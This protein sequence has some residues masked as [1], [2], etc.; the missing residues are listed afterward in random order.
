M[1]NRQESLVIKLISVGL[2]HDLSRLEQI[3]YTKEGDTMKY[4]EAEYVHLHRKMFAALL[5]LGFVVKDYSLRRLCVQAAGVC[6]PEGII[7]KEILENLPRFDAP[8]TLE[9]ER[10]KTVLV[11]LREQLE[12]FQSP[13]KADVNL[14]A[15]WLKSSALCYENLD[16][17]NRRKLLSENLQPLEYPGVEKYL[18][19]S[20][21]ESGEEQE[22]EKEP[23]PLD[24]P[25]VIEE[26]KT[27]ELDISQR[28]KRIKNPFRAPNDPAIIP[29]TP[30]EIKAVI[31][32]ALRESKDFEM[33]RDNEMFMRVAMP[34][35][36]LKSYRI[37]FF[38]MNKEQM[39]NNK[40]N[41]VF[42]FGMTEETDL[43]V[44]QMYQEGIVRVHDL[45]CQ[46][47]N[48]FDI[49]NVMLYAIMEKKNFY[50]MQEFVALNKNQSV[51]VTKNP[52]QA[53]FFYLTARPLPQH[54]LLHR[55]VNIAY[56]ST[57]M[58]DYCV[59]HYT[60]DATPC[61][62]SYKKKG[63]E[64]EEEEDEEGEEEVKV[65]KP[66]PLRKPTEMAPKPARKSI[67]PTSKPPPPPKTLT[68]PVIRTHKAKRPPAVEINTV[69]PFD[70]SYELLS[71]FL[72]MQNELSNIIGAKVT[73][74]MRPMSIAQS[75]HKV[76]F[77]YDTT[78]ELPVNVC[79]LRNNKLT[80][81]TTKV[82]TLPARIHGNLVVTFETIDAIVY[83]ENNE[84][85]IK[86]ERLPK[87][88]GAITFDHMSHA[89]KLMNIEC[90]VGNVKSNFKFSMRGGS[91]SWEKKTKEE[92]KQR[93]TDHNSTSQSGDGIINDEMKMEIKEEIKDEIKEEIK[94]EFKEYSYHEMKVKTEPNHRSFHAPQS[95]IV[96]NQS[97]IRQ[98][99][100]QIVSPM[101]SMPGYQGHYSTP[102]SHSSPVIVK[103]NSAF[104]QQ[105]P[106]Q[107]QESG[108][109]QVMMQMQQPNFAV[110]H[111]Q[112]QPPEQINNCQAQV[113]NHED[114]QQLLPVNQPQSSV[115]QQPANH[116]HPQY[117]H[118]QFHSP[119]QPNHYS[120]FQQTPEPPQ[121]YQQTNIS[122]PQYQTQPNL[123]TSTPNLSPEASVIV[124]AILVSPK[125]D[126][127]ATQT[128]K[129]DKCR[130][131]S[132]EDIPPPKMSFS[133]P[134]KPEAIKNGFKPQVK[135]NV[136]QELNGIDFEAELPA[137]QVVLKVKVEEAPVQEQ[138]PPT[139]PPPLHY[140][141]KKEVIEPSPKKLVLNPLN[142]VNKI[143]KED[144]MASMD[145][146]LSNTPPADVID[147][148]EDYCEQ[149]RIKKF[150]QNE[151]DPLAINFV[152]IGDMPSSGI[153]MGK[154][155]LDREYSRVLKKV[156]M[157][158]LGPGPKRQK[159]E[160][161]DDRL[162]KIRDAQVY[163]IDVMEEFK[164]H[165]VFQTHMQVKTRS[166]RLKLPS[167]VSIFMKRE[168]FYFNS[169]F[170]SSKVPATTAATFSS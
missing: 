34:H 58:L 2:S 73:I 124:S 119:T 89:I 153:D 11:H 60:F 112:Q 90:T 8:V 134:L 47:L 81:I 22:E 110:H 169:R 84:P 163:V 160:F 129:A 70:S 13:I 3:K 111:F 167:N 18:K 48:I 26:L 133:G 51:K 100:V 16:F 25:K 104:V 168:F 149:P 40:A 125:V 113:Y 107:H 12:T 157:K 164:E 109:D 49:E 31:I 123:I 35:E 78:S 17:L 135:N 93:E 4:T 106:Q 143:K 156:G 15:T 20:R 147:L 162:K 61:R 91:R 152:D 139:S 130:I 7:C 19:R 146:I 41:L 32:K 68:P 165:P 115:N 1:P 21:K 53:A 38:G 74:D 101:V 9:D 5:T 10:M 71:V 83:D 97:P 150:H 28:L 127:V 50:M 102:L 118:Q 67:E 85:K 136:N 86:T 69:E 39:K 77:T 14:A 36:K 30:S 52:V 76:T 43:T 161:D 98:A 131:L 24:A 79:S 159:L 138:T 54:A 75:Q 170:N 29:P 141:V 128:T 95:V 94:E 137:P 108:H 46:G 126:T 145:R 82:L 33:L 158:K 122:P 66:K 121:Q 63:E 140:P 23:Q 96:R 132:V 144:M 155:N 142:V 65:V 120:Q 59:D 64:G 62:Y 103:N 87:I 44:T 148:T 55:T 42:D 57:S 88:S 72:L 154:C 151:M 166:V 80:H 105:Q 99:P 45:C 117:H 27:F 37:Y 56:T 116:Q 6:E 114:Q 92:R